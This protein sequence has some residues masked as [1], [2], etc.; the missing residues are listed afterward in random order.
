M[1]VCMY[2]A[3]D[4]DSFRRQQQLIWEKDINVIKTTTTYMAETSVIFVIYMREKEKEK[5]RE[6]ES[7]RKKERESVCVCERERDISP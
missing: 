3:R 4:K 7:K 5:E 6:R 1:Y 2:W